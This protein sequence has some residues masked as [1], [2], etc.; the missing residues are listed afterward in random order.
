LRDLYKNG[1]VNKTLVIDSEP[2]EEVVHIIH[3]SRKNNP[4]K[5][6]II[7]VDDD[8]ERLTGYNTRY[9]PQRK[10]QQQEV[11]YINRSPSPHQQKIVYAMP[12]Q[13]QQQQ[14]K[15]Q[16]MY[17]K[18]QAPSVRYVYEDPQQDQLPYNYVIENNDYASSN[19]GRKQAPNYVYYETP[20][21]EKRIVY[22]DDYN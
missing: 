17:V 12:K 16:I 15:Q 2:E 7:Y 22:A 9:I 10:Q 14:R 1:S 19:G 8:D 3:K 20:R 18:E 4:V 13:Q 21:T 11:V 6:Q 5:E